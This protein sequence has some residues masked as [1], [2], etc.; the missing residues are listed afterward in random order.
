MKRERYFPQ[1]HSKMFCLFSFFL[2]IALSLSNISYS[3]AKE[4]VLT[5]LNKQ[6][7]LKVAFTFDEQAVDIAFISPSGVRKDASSSDVQVA[8][9]T[10]WSTYLISNAEAGTWKVDYDLGPNTQIDYSI[11]DDDYGLWI[12]DFSVTAGGDGRA[13]VSF[14]ADFSEGDISYNYELYALSQDDSDLVSKVDAGSA[15]ANRKQETSVDMNGLAAGIYTLRLDVYY[16]DG[17]GEVFDSKTSDTTLTSA[18]QTQGLDFTVQVN[19]GKH[20]SYIDWSDADG[21]YEAFALTAYADGAETTSTTFV[22]GLGNTRVL[23]PAEAKSLSYTLRGKKNGVWADIQKKDIDLTKE[24][25]TMEEGEVTSDSQVK[26]SY[27]GAGERT[28]YVAI[29]EEDGSYTVS[30]SGFLSFALTEGTNEIFAEMEADN[31]VSYVI[32]QDLYLDTIPPE[33]NLFDKLDGKT[34]YTD[35]ALLL[36]KIEGGNIL[37]IDGKEV[38]LD[39]ENSFAYEKALLPGENTVRLDAED[40][41]GNISTMILTL[42]RASK[43]L[44]KGFSLKNVRDILPLLIGLIGSAII[45]V[46]SAI[47]MKKKENVGKVGEK[48]TVKRQSI[49]PVLWLLIC[50]GLSAVFIWQFLVHYIF[51]HSGAFLTM[52]EESALK[53]AKY[54]KMERIFFMCSVVALAAFILSIVVFSLTQRRRKKKM[55]LFEDNTQ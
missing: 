6:G 9:G 36:G 20:E 28:L 45:I 8:K 22:P 50:G 11:I 33:I 34:F 5:T 1:K 3:E 44:T 35:S 26:I 2:V 32:D 51:S 27:T 31:G 23:F 48:T 30:D 52:A 21:F 16:D 14:E 17:E 43:L 10:Y 53:A 19:C 49:W 46:F 18:A 15:T 7:D 55:P 42:N 24:S 4:A 40:A 41:N 13:A 54:I 38:S 29:N 25:L 37:R 12:T 39:K 47:F